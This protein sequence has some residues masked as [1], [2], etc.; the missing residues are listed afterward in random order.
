[1]ISMFDD[2]DD[3]VDTFNALLV[4]VLNEH[5][6]IKRI[7]IKARPHPFIYRRNSPANE[8]PRHVA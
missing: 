5:A 7:A 1:M 8:H 3:Q 2:L 6:P 4:D